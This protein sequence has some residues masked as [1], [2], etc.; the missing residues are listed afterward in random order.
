MKV[1]QLNSKI[2]LGATFTKVSDGSLVDPT[3]IVLYIRFPDQ[4]EQVY[5]IA[6][7][8]VRDSLG[9]YHFDLTVVRSG[10]YFYKWEGDGSVQVSS[11]D[12]FFQVASSLLIEG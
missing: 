4:T 3:T 10:G 6:E 2:Q 12:K 7:G 8:I 5:G 1:Y 11:P 9:V